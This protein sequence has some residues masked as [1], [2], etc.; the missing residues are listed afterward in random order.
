MNL[1]EKLI[2]LGDRP[3]GRSANDPLYLKMVKILGKD[4]TEL[5]YKLTGNQ[6]LS[7]INALDSERAKMLLV[8]DFP[9][10]KLSLI[11]FFTVIGFTFFISVGISFYYYLLAT[12]TDQDM[13]KYIE[14]VSKL[15]DFIT[16]IIPALI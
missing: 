6:I 16:T 2:Y 1:Q 12:N 4:L 14:L 3:V 8:M 11:K 13:S 15:L 5:N 9:I 7:L 10:S